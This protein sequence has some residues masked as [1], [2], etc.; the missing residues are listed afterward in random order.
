MSMS[1]DAGHI[2]ENRA[3]HGD[4]GIS[5]TGVYK[6]ESKLHRFHDSE[7]HRVRPLPYR[8]LTV[9]YIVYEYYGIVS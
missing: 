6:R 8:F 7:I 4:I 9:R 3:F 1:N 2:M 5:D